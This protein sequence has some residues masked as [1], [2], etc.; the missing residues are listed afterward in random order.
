MKWHKFSLFQISMGDQLPKIVCE[1]CAF[2]LDE[3]FDFREKCQN[4]EN[5]FLSMLEQMT[6]KEEDP[7]KPIDLEILESHRKRMR[8]MNNLQNHLNETNLDEGMQTIHVM[9]SMDLNVAEQ[10]VLHEVIPEKDEIEDND[11]ND[12][13]K[14]TANMVIYLWLSRV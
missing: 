14:K 3:L 12:L 11:V 13:E 4:T 7:L 1:E 9:K 10:V 5:M 8:N 2:K 6:S